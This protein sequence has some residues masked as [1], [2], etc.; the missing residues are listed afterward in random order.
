MQHEN[1]S[2]KA[3]RPWNTKKYR[4]LKA[5]LLQ[6]KKNGWTEELIVPKWREK[7]IEKLEARRSVQF[8]VKRN[9]FIMGIYFTMRYMYY[10]EM[11]YFVIFSEAVLFP[12]IHNDFLLIWWPV[13]K[14]VMGVSRCQGLS[15]G[16]YSKKANL[17]SN[18][19]HYKIFP[20]QNEI[21]SPGS[22]VPNCNNCRQLFSSLEQSWIIWPWWL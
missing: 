11:K 10:F 6:K 1:N 16:H 13:R 5:N 3:D 18:V 15:L 14:L 8:S 7:M 20:H 9:I 17:F 2:Q 4:H 12:M 19:W 22:D 21:T